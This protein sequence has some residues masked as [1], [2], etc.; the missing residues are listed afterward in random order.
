MGKHGSPP[1]GDKR[2]RDGRKTAELTE[3]FKADIKVTV[4]DAALLVGCCKG[5]AG[6]VKAWV[7]RGAIGPIYTRKFERGFTARKQQNKERVT[8]TVRCLVCDREFSSESKWT[9]TCGLCI[10]IR[11]MY[12]GNGVSEYATV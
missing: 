7:K 2:Y 1:A 3:I 5:Y 10:P 4:N 6:D 9:R 8:V 12:S 11:N